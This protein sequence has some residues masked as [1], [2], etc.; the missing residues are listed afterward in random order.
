MASRNKP[1]VIP[2]IGLIAGWGEFPFLV[3]QTMQQK[4]KRVAAVA[5]PGETFPEIKT[6]VDELHWISIGQLG[7]MIKI[8]KTAGITQVVMAGMIRHKHL[9]A[10]LKLDLK[11]VSLLATMKDKRA[12]SILC[13]VA[14]VLE[15]EGIRLVSP[16]PYLKVNLPG[17][18]LLTKRK[19]TQKEQRDIT[20]GYK[21]AKHVARADIGQTVVVKDQAVIAVE[22]ME[23]TDACILRSGEFTRGGAV[24]IKVLKPTQDLRFDTPVIGPNTIES[25]LKVKAAVLAFDADKTLFLQKEKTIVMA[26]KKKITLIGV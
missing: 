1:A 10:N 11:A 23:G 19:L 3:A 16:L 7:E 6:C 25:M 26:N 5:F 22:A 17:K 9:F 13:A 12:D 2:K 18:G 24:V 15:K 14:G 8:F 21:I 4:G 20:F